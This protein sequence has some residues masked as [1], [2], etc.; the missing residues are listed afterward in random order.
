M[1]LYR[2]YA[3]YQNVMHY[4]AYRGVA[5]NLMFKCDMLRSIFRVALWSKHWKKSSRM[6]QN[7]WICF[8]IMPIHFQCF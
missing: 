6:L 8:S 1:L 4:S 3:Y 5:M 7:F 2:W